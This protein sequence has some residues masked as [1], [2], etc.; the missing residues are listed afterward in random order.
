MPMLLPGARELT[1]GSFRDEVVRYHALADSGDGTAARAYGEG[2]AEL[3]PVPYIGGAGLLIVRRTSRAGVQ[4]IDSALVRRD[5]LAPVWEVSET[6]GWRRR[7]DYN[8]AD[9]RVVAT[10]ADST[11]TSEHEY[12]HPVFHFNE[13]DVLIRAVPLERGYRAIVPLYSEGDDA[14]EMDSI[15]VDRRN[16][17]GTWDVRFADKVTVSHYG[18]DP[19]SRAIVSRVTVWRGRPNRFHYAIDSVSTGAAGD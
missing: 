7:F 3:H 4:F 10:S 6:R 13:L 5:G 2:R 18:I 15:S 9:V 8:G 17:S 16:P 14:L 1:T 11:R 19:T 12:P